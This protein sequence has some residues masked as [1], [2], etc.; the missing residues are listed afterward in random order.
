VSA[1]KQEVYYV[2]ETLPVRW[3]AGRRDEW[4]ERGGRAKPPAYEANEWGLWQ[5]HGNVVEWCVDVYE[6]KAY[7]N[8]VSGAA[9]GKVVGE[10]RVEADDAAEAQLYTV[11]PS[12]VLRG[13]S[14]VSDGGAL[15]CADRY[16]G[17]PVV[18]DLIVG[19]RLSWES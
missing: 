17:A 13:G 4:T 12:R 14:W 3:D 9:A 2:E 7:E 8:R 10:V 1:G 11:G 18:R 6:E 15:R 16:G 19:L 5:M